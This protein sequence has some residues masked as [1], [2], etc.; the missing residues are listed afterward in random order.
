MTLG[1]RASGLVNGD[2]EDGLNGWTVEG[3][4]TGSETT[5]N[6]V[7]FFQENPL[8]AVSRI[9]QVFDL[10]AVPQTLT[11]KFYMDWY[12]ASAPPNSPDTWP[13]YEGMVE[14]FLDAGGPVYRR[15]RWTS[16]R[17]PAGRR[18]GWSS[19]WRAAPTGSRPSPSWTMSSTR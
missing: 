1:A 9:Y 13:H 19:A 15:S 4:V 8:G 3:S 12:L 16:P 7:A 14:L 17:S 10:P 11:F 5:G 6:D 2:F 18:S